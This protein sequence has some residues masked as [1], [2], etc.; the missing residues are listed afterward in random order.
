M[1]RN[2]S[3]FV[4]PVAALCA[5]SL[6]AAGLALSGCEAESADDFFFGEVTIQPSSITMGSSDSTQFTVAGGDGNYSW[7]VS[8]T[9]LGNVVQ[10]GENATYT[11]TGVGTNFLTVTDSTGDSDTATI[12]QQ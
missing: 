5:L 2:A 9:G 12:W 7:Q 8:N 1:K 4:L 3:R 10:S 6:L 11:S